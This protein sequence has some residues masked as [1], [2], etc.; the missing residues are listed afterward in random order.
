MPLGA[1]VAFA[2]QYLN[3]G[4]VCIALYGDGAANQ[5]Q[6]FEAY[7]M[8]ALW[9]LPVIYVCENN[10]YGMGTSA[11]RASA[12]TA[13]YSRGDYIPGIWVSNIKLKVLN[14]IW[15]NYYLNKP[16]FL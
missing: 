8:S 13:Y 14:I 4:G 16:F 12:S 5:G 2:Y 7:N 9:K 15:K 10:G 3:T 6:V 11:E 1:G